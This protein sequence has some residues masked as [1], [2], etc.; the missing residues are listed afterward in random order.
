MP[1]LRGGSNINILN[2]NF[3][4]AGGFGSP[5]AVIAPVAQID[6]SSKT[7]NSPAAE[8][9]RLPAG[10]VPV[11]RLAAIGTTGG[12][13]DMQ[14]PLQCACTVTCPGRLERSKAGNSFSCCGDHA[15]PAAEPEFIPRADQAA[16]L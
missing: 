11:S 13:G 3:A 14:L 1:A 9:R 8:L 4:F 2:S 10:R 6:A 15:F 5:A 7:T 12:F 16:I